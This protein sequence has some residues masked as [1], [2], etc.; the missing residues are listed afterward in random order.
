MFVF[1][2]RSKVFGCCID[3]L[4]LMSSQETLEID[5]SEHEKLTGF[6]VIDRQKVFAKDSDGYKTSYFMRREDRKGFILI[7]E[8]S[9][10]LSQVHITGKSTLE[11]ISTKKFQKV[12]MCNELREMLGQEASKIQ[13]Q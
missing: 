1:D 2:S 9:Q 3:L 5:P 13:E 6:F 8:D 10:S 11:L 4:Q 12:S 7:D